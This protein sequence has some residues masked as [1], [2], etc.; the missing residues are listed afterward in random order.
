MERRAPRPRRP[1][2]R[3]PRSLK[4]QSLK[5]HQSPVCHLVVRPASATPTDTRYRKSFAETPK[6]VLHPPKLINNPWILY[7]KERLAVRTGLMPGLIL[8]LRRIILTR[9]S[10]APFV[11]AMPKEEK[12][13][14]AELS[15]E[16]VKDFRN[17]PASERAVRDISKSCF[18]HR[19]L[20]LLTESIIH[21]LQALDERL[22]EHKKQFEVELKEYMEGITPEM[23]A[24]E[25]KYR[26][27][28]RKTG[29]RTSKYTLLR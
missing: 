3:R 23:I 27:T 8:Y 11:Q 19:S 18:D 16:L 12:T 14:T 10:S 7:F 20:F 13:K 1:P 24:E 29:K 25:N 6:R 9:T 5:L 26:R 22:A 4:S 28:K 17:L 21:A 15:V 2:Q